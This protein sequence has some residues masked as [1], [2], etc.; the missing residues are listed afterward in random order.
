MLLNSSLFLDSQD[1]EVLLFSYE[2]LWMPDLIV[3]NDIGKYDPWK[4]KDFLPLVVWG[5]GTVQWGF[6]APMQTTCTMDVTNFPFDSHDCEIKIY[7]SIL[8]ILFDIQPECF[9]Q[10]ILMGYYEGSPQWEITGSISFFVTTSIPRASRC[11][12]WR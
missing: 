12:K 11:S 9:E 1:L 7:S 10:Q 4:Y 2:E 6:P 5:D 3:F 8:S